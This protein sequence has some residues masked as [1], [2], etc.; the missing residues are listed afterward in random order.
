MIDDGVALYADNLS[1][2]ISHVDQNGSPVSFLFVQVKHGFT[3]RSR[4]ETGHHNSEICHSVGDIVNKESIPDHKTD[5]G[6][7][8][9]PFHT[10]RFKRFLSAVNHKPGGA[11]MDDHAGNIGQILGGFGEGG[12]DVC[13]CN[14]RICPFQ[15]NGHL[16]G[17][18]MCKGARNTDIDF[19]DFGTCLF[20][21]VADGTAD[22]LVELA[23]I[24]PAFLKISV[25]LRDTGRNNVAALASAVFGN[26]R[27]NLAGTEVDGRNRRFHSLYNLPCSGSTGEFL[28]INAHDRY[29]S[30]FALVLQEFVCNLLQFLCNLLQFYQIFQVYCGEDGE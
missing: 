11:G 12:F 5:V 30:L 10:D 26:Q 17:I 27:N 25:I 8:F 2:Q 4:E 24:V 29:Y 6:S 22:C 28:Q 20:F 18:N 9:P 13:G 15:G 19:A 23:R 1:I 7:H 3:R 21:G 14:P 16:G